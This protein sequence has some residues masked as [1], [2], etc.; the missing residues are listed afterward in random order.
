MKLP[1]LLA[2]KIDV[3]GARA[4]KTLPALAELLRRHQAGASFAVSFGP[5]FLPG[6]TLGQADSLRQLRDQGFEIGIHGW[7]SG[8]WVKRI[9]QA[10]AA[11]S[12]QQLERAIAAFQRSLEAPPRFH[13]APGW[14][15]NPHAL[16]LTQRLGFSHACDTRGRHPFVPVWNGEIVRCIQIPTTLPTLDELAGKGKVDPLSLVTPLLALTADPPRTGHVFSL[17]ASPQLVK[18]P[19]A[20]EALLTGWREQ[21]YELASVQALASRC[22]IDKLTRHEI[23]VGTVAGRSGPVLLQGEEFLS[24]WRTTT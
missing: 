23:V 18:N 1:P 21:G 17:T 7:S 4:A 13:A 6:T 8:Q 16:R 19:A 14:R 20:L 3:P 10:D 15:S 22:E 11:W 24:T 9:E 2:L 5:G 12:Q